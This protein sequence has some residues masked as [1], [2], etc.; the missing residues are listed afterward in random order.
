MTER[1]AFNFDK[2]IAGFSITERGIKSWSKSF[3]IGPFNRRYP[4]DWYFKTQ[5]YSV[6]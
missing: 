6:G 1:S 4:R 3:K 2:T 5:H